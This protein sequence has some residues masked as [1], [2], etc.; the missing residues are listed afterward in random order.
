MDVRK[1][2]LELALPFERQPEAVM[3]LG[4]IG[5][6]VDGLL[7]RCDGFF[8][9][10]QFPERVT[11]SAVRFG[12]VGPDRNGLCTASQSDERVVLN[13]ASR[14]VSARKRY[15]VDLPEWAV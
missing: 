3:R 5:L 12:E 13:A 6:E 8:V 14:A 11:E 10:A 1:G 7:L 9:S 2:G 15:K 4:E